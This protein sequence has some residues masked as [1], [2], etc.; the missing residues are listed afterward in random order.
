MRIERVTAH[1]F[2]PLSDATLE[3]GPGMTLVY[4]PNEAGKS[5]WHAALYAGLCGVRR[6]KGQPVIADREF[7]DDHKPWD[8]DRWDAE[9]L[10]RLAD[11][12][13]IEL[14][15][16]LAG[17][18]DSRA[19]DVALGTDVSSEIM[20]DGSPDGSRW[21]GLDRRAFLATACINQAQLLAISDDP[22][23]LQEHIQRA[24]ATRGTDAT[25][26]A[27][28][29]RLET[30]R[31]VQV[32]EDRANSTKPLHRAKV[33]LDEAQRDLG[34]AQRKHAAFLEAAAE[35]D[36]AGERADRAKAGQRVLVAAVATDR[37]AG[38]RARADR[39][40]EL[41]ARH[42]EGAPAGFAASDDLGNR[43]ASALDAWDHRPTTVALDGPGAGM[44][45]LELRGLPAMPTGDLDLAD[46]VL[47]A[48]TDYERR[49]EAR[50]LAAEPPTG[51]PTE[52]AAHA[53]IDLP[54]PA[55]SEGRPGGSTSRRPRV[56]AGGAV[57]AAVIGLAALALGSQV[58]GVLLVLVAAALGA[59]AIVDRRIAV[60]GR[61][62]GAGA[63]GVDAAAA[64]RL[65]VAL[66][67][68]ERERASRASAALVAERSAA[69]RDAEATLAAVLTTHGTATEAGADLEAAFRQYRA[70]CRSRSELA[71]DAGRA[72]ALQ[73]AIVARWD[74]E[75]RA[76]ERTERLAAIEGDLRALSTDAGMAGASET[77]PATI[78]STLREWLDRHNQETGTREAAL[79]EWR[80]LQTLLDGRTP[81]D[82][83]EDAI[84][85]DGRAR[86]RA[87]GLDP[88]TIVAARA[89]LGP[90][91]DR[92]LSD[93]ETVANESR[94]EA[95]REAG[96]LAEI[97]RGLPSV[98]EAEE[99]AEAARTEVDRVTDLDVVLQTTMHLLRE[100][101][102]RIHRDL[103]PLL[104][105]AIAAQ[106]P[107]I[108]GGRYVEAAVNPADLAVR[109]KTAD[110][111]QWREAKRLSH[112]TREQIYLLL[113]LAMTQHLV[114]EDEVA[115]LLCDEVTVQSDQ[116]RA[117]QLL[118]LLHE[119]SRDR[120][121]VVFTHDE[122]ALTWA[123]TAL[124]GE[125]DRLIRLDEAA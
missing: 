90:D 42:P 39:A 2:G 95:A 71:R 72:A 101:E 91:P 17:R 10:V 80:E 121:V 111:G 35:S 22:G 69:L 57:G 102:T 97:E 15:Q 38:A 79:L 56:L 48:R 5:S 123:E 51:A 125:G 28:L 44:L 87:A 50:R 83:E 92:K 98:A 11:G 104:G 100:A 8:G 31:R 23:L 105:A 27:A 68:A 62:G 85:L 21:L 18:V 86:E 115:P 96:R 1:A 4:G 52:P 74:L 16:D 73:E 114:R 113:R 46:E 99:L 63:A 61:L 94:A 33:E 65:E 34:A 66:R 107:R 122:R 32:G 77:D 6:G 67:E 43:V 117:T 37:A 118:E 84:R 45:E 108:S 124:D 20:F 59:A 116:R 55:E 112:G 30:F 3:L 19:T 120:Q 14:R 109:V 24:A 88:A 9:V 64:A 40:A 29:D 13:R 103:A 70:D 89:T 26:A 25:A 82:L 36:A 106:L 54:P 60:P 93:L 12:R 81:A 7:R 78:A 49:L 47:Q 58:V 76:R 119:V 53:D 41:V 110:G 75:S